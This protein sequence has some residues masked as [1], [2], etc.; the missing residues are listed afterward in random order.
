M[1]FVPQVFRGCKCNNKCI[2]GSFALAIHIPHTE[3]MNIVFLVRVVQ[4]I[5][6]AS[7]CR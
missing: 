7:S 6:I 2:P 4:L 3:D 1:C 5:R